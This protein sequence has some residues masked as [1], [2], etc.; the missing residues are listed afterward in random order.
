MITGRLVGGSIQQSGFIFLSRLRVSNKPLLQR[1]L[2]KHLLGSINPLAAIPAKAIEGQ[3]S[4][5]RQQ[6]M[7]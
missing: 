7:S 4:D 3:G 5:R 6:G 1:T 2:S